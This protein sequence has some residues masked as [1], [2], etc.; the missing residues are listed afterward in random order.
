MPEIRERDKADQ[1]KR[2]DKQPR[3]KKSI[4]APVKRSLRAA[5]GRNI[6]RQGNN[7]S[8]AESTAAA[9]A[10]AAQQVQQA[11]ESIMPRSVD[12]AQRMK[13]AFQQ[14]RKKEAERYTHVTEEAPPVSESTSLSPVK[15]RQPPTSSTK[16]ASTP[17]VSIRERPKGSS[18][19]KVRQETILKTRQSAEW[20]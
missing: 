1:L 18:S 3:E 19:P 10:H 13:Y 6:R 15:Q 20:G 14:Q 11:A 8:Q 2:K 12:A 7:S 9:D 5:I 17:M 4:G 16:P